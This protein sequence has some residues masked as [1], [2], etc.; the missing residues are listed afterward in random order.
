MRQRILR[1]QL[2]RDP[3]GSSTGTINFTMRP[4]RDLLRACI[5]YMRALFAAAPLG[6]LPAEYIV[7]QFRLAGAVTPRAAQPFRAASKSE[8]RAFGLLLRLGLI[9]EPEPG[10]Y[11]LDQESV[12]AMRRQG[13]LPWK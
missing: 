9:R 12:D 5:D 4:F 8:V 3:L 2:K 13:V 1:P 11:Y 6:L 7:Q 10:R